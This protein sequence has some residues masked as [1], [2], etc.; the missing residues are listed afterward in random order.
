MTKLCGGSQVSVRKITISLPPD[1]VADLDYLGGRL[2][3]SR[4]AIIAE[5]LGE[6]APLLARL[7]RSVPVQEN[8]TP[9]VIRRAKGASL[10]LI[11]ELMGSL[12]REYSDLVASFGPEPA[13]PR[14]RKG[15]A[16]V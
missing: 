4:S 12:K 1:L 10:E 16:R 3:I 15:A 6:T 11:E 8:A 14:A 5:L 2:G 13:K 9:A 7:L